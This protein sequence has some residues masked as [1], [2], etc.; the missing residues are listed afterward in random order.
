MMMMK[1]CIQQHK[2]HKKYMMAIERIDF[3]VNHLFRSMKFY[4]NVLRSFAEIQK[5][6]GELKMTAKNCRHFDVNKRYIV[7]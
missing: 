4:L 6:E 2:I 7:A 5:G 1:T 3:S